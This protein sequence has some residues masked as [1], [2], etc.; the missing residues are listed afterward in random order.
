MAAHVAVDKVRPHGDPRIQLRSAHLNGHTYGYIYSIPPA[1]TPNRGSI[2]LVHGFPDLSLA[3]RYQIP[4]LT[5]LGLT[6]IAIDCLGYGRSDAPPSSALSKYGFKRAADDIAELCRQLSLT[7]V[8]LGGHDWG[9]AIVYRVAQYHPTL[10]RALFSVCTPYFPPQTT[11][12]PHALLV[13]TRLRNFQYQLEYASGVMEERVC[14]KAELRQFLAGAFLAQGPSG[15]I[16]A[17]ATHGMFWEDLPRLG[18]SPLLGDDEMDYYV[19]EYARHGISGPVNWYRN[20]EVNFMDEYVY[21]FANG[22]ALGAKPTVEQEVLFILAS[23]DDALP[24][25]MSDSMGEYIPR[26]TREQVDCG[27]WALW[28]RAAEINDMVAKWLNDKVFE[29]EKGSLFSE[30]RGS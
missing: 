6:C 27:H 24:P 11:F 23:E 7:S 10:V 15:E 12:L 4:H 2:I 14:S 26:L 9:G 18:K 8:I 5:S 28:Q 13:A 16:V 22:E 20:R 29:G 25:S 30:E 1:S 19:N 17:T 3:W 21:F